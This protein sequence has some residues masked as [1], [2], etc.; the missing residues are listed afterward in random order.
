MIKFNDISYSNGT[1]NGDGYGDR[2][3]NGYGD[4]CYGFDPIHGFDPKHG[5]LNE[6]P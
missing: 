5:E 6:L 4:G 2:N 3:E 1:W